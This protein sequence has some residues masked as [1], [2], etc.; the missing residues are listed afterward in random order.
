LGG[1]LR[2]SAPLPRRSQYRDAVSEHGKVSELLRTRMNE[3]DVSTEYRKLGYS[4]GWTF[5]MTPAAR[6]L[7]ARVC[8]VG[9][10]PGGGEAGDELWSCEDGNAYNVE[11]NWGR[12]PGG[13]VPLQV[14]VQEM[15]R[16]LGL[17]ADD[18]LAAQLIPFRSP[19][20]RS[21]KQA[22]EAAAFGRKLWAWVMET[23]PARLFLCLGHEVTEHLVRVANA[24]PR[25]GPPLETRWG[26]T[27]IGCYETS[28]SGDD[29]RVI[30]RLPHL[31]SYRIF[32]RKDGLS[33]LAERSLRDA[34]RPN[35]AR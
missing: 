20:Y 11:K 30:V 21:L 24:K 13:L 7:D 6:L 19:D 26:K 33:Q 16:L 22:H 14:Q 5:M 3:A 17:G 27:T 34:C 9:L 28:P 29:R 35:V 2:P 10:N 4:L 15:A 31:S 1:G 25:P 12:G 18:Y 32:G 23:S 8:L